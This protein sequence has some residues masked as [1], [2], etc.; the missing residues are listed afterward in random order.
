VTTERQPER[1]SDAEIDADVRETLRWDMRVDDTGIDVAVV[2]GK[3]RL[4]GKVSTLSEKMAAEEDVRRIRGVR[5]VSNEVFVEPAA[6]RRDEDIARDVVLALHRD[7]RIDARHTRVDVRG[8]IVRLS[9]DVHTLAQKR[10]AGE[11]AWYTAGVVDIVNE[12]R[13]MPARHR[14]DSAIDADVRTVLAAGGHVL[15]PTRIHVS[16]QQG[17]VYLRGDVENEVERHAAEEAARIVSGVRDVV[18]ELEIAPIAP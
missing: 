2:D 16:V 5:E 12:L 4:M 17:V 7:R 9:G 14:P 8:G 13:V 3:V 15:D 10:A 18:N 6:L 11:D 1:R